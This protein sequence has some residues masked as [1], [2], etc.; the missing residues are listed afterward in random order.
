MIM[1]MNLIM[2]RNR[3]KIMIMSN[4]LKVRLRKF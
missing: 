3:I 4:L 1:I 2:I